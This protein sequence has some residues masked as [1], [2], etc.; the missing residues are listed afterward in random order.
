M[1]PFRLLTY[2]VASLLEPPVEGDLRLV[3]AA[4]DA[5]QANLASMTC[6]EL[7]ATYRE[8]G[9]G[10][11]ESR[12][13]LRTVW[14]DN[15]MF[16]EFDLT[17]ALPPAHASKAKDYT[18]HYGRMIFNGEFYVK[19]VPRGRTAGEVT[20]FTQAD[21]REKSPSYVHFD[22]RP[23][24]RWAK[25]RGLRTWKELLGP[26]PSFPS[27]N[28]QKWVIKQSGRNVVSERHNYD[29]ESGAGKA[30]WL[31]S[32]DFAGNVIEGKYTSKDFNEET[33]LTWR[34]DA[35]GKVILERDWCRTQTSDGTLQRELSISDF[36]LNPP[37][38]PGQFEMSALLIRN[39]AAVNDL[40]Q[41]RR[42]T[43][44]GRTVD[45]SSLDALSEQVKSR[46]FSKP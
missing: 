12:M 8:W 9:D 10:M 5:Q 33:R 1:E 16:W 17:S 34:K 21:Y 26:H 4:L 19:Y 7:R 24:V 44:G 37:I 20:I 29:S 41:R 15:K 31:C 28:I 43:F 6:G 38:K 46:G 22:Q 23:V 25:C 18:P 40:I 42:Y 27:D 45:Q 3:Q 11:T 32:L 36:R 13:S 30:V 35:D 14:Q 39:G 2:L